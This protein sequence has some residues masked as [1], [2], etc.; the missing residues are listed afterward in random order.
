VTF[1]YVESA[2]GRL[3]LP[4]YNLFE[5]LWGISPLASKYGSFIIGYGEKKE[6]W[7]GRRV[8]G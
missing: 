7:K 8:E 1:K 5:I 6:G 2:L 3:V 4:F